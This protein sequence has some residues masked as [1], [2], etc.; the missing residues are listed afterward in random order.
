MST[1]LRLALV[2]LFVTAATTGCGG[3]R[4]GARSPENP[5][6]QDTT[7]SASKEDMPPAPMTDIA[8]APVAPTDPHTSVGAAG[9]MLMIAPMKVSVLKPAKTDKPVELAAD[10][11]VKVDGKPVAKIKGDEI[12]STEG[13]SMLTVGVTGALVGNGVKQGLRFDGDDVVGDDVVA[14]EP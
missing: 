7:E 9:G 3:D 2:L 4:K 6:N 8:N 1:R 14:V 12:G 11:T 5:A 10:G 13:T